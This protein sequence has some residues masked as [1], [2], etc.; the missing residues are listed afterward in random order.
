MQGAVA[1][2]PELVEAPLTAPA[3]GGATPPSPMERQLSQLSL[4][5][6]GEKVGN[7]TRARRGHIVFYDRVW[8][9]QM[10]LIPTQV[11]KKTLYA[12]LWLVQ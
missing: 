2:E 7:N 3:A 9:D 1:V 12:S 5:A 6:E 4:K 10:R 8:M 11:V